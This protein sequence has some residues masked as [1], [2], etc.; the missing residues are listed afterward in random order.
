M[1]GPRAMWAFA[2]TKCSS[3]VGK[4]GVVIVLDLA[5]ARRRMVDRQVARRG[6]HDDR[7]LEAMRRVPREAFVETGLEEFAYQN[8]PLPIGQGQTISQPYVV[9]LMIEAAELK[10]GDSGL[11]VGSGCGYTAAVRLRLPS[12][13]TESNA[14]HRSQKL[15]GSG[16]EILGTETSAC[17]SAMAHAVGLK[18]RR[19]TP[20]SSRPVVRRCHHR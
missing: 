8:R 5:R 1:H 9:A 12:V 4:Q 16:S 7:V 18:R 11:E 2:L 3:L 20:S 13:C 6:I 15:P 10:P 19:L 17:V 14:I